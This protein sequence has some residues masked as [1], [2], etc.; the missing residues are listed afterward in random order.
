MSAL[1][2]SH[3]D[4]G[5]G[6]IALRLSRV[7]VELGCLACAIG[8]GLPLAAILPSMVRQVWLVVFRGSST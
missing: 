3:R 1:R 7:G 8:A 5:R 2:L 4:R 6:R